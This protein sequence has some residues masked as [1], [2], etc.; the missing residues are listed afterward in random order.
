MIRTILT[1]GVIFMLAFRL[2]AAPLM[3][4]QAEAGKIALCVGGQ[5]VYLTWDEATPGDVEV[6]GESCPVLGVTAALTDLL[7][8]PAA[9][10]T[11][12]VATL[13]PLVPKQLVQAETATPYLSRAPPISN[14]M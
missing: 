4:P 2:V 13:A 6:V 12:L 9:P 1:M 3:M 14:V 5:I 7:P 10:A 8:E 11:L